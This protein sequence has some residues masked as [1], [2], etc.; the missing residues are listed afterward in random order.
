MNGITQRHLGI[1]QRSNEELRDTI[2]RFQA[3]W[4][5]KARRIAER[6]ND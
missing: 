5:L 6:Y 1:T 3:K 4:D 2:N